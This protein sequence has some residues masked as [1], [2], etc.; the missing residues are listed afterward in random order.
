MVVAKSIEI[1][2]AHFLPNYEGKCR[3]LHGHRWKIELAVEGEVGEVSGMV[4]DF[5]DLKRFLDFIKERLDHHLI[6]DIIPNPT[7]ENICLYV[8]SELIKDDWGFNPD[9]WKWIRVWETRDSVAELRHASTGMT[10]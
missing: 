8:E 7:A 1:D 10:S 4:I 5:T 9:M 3:D 6:N 2:A